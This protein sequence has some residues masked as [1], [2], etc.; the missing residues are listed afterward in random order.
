M[1]LFLG[2]NLSSNNQPLIDLATQVTST[3]DQT[4]SLLD[5]ISKREILDDQKLNQRLNRRTAHNI[6]PRPNTA[7]TETVPFSQNTKVFI[8]FAFYLCFLISH[9]FRN[10]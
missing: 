9:C 8:L 1:F 3:S 10:L 6:Q 5:P 7:F 2:G 4:L